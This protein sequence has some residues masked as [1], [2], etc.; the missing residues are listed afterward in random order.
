MPYPLQKI[1][2]GLRCRLSDLATPVERYR[3]QTAAGKIDICPT[4]PQLIRKTAGFP[5]ARIVY[6]GKHLKI[7]MF[8]DLAEVRLTDFTNDNLWDHEDS[9]AII[10]ATA[11]DLIRSNMFNHLLIRPQ[12]LRLS[13]CDIT[14]RFF[15][16]LKGSIICGS[17][18]I[19]HLVELNVDDINFADIFATLPYITELHAHYVVPNSTWMSDILTF[20]KNKLM[21]MEILIDNVDDLMAGDIVAFLD[22]QEKDFELLILT[23]MIP[24]KAMAKLRAKFSKVLKKYAGGQPLCPVVFI[25]HGDRMYKFEKRDV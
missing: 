2:Y 25:R 20:Q 4:K 15:K 22:A 12:V 14:Q 9:L 21:K 19:L 18:R 5:N 8:N 16:A 1:K 6:D 3:L 17:V 10:G 11:Y 13:S 23:S 24:N 7:T